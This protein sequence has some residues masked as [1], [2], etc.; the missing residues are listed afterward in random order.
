[1]EKRQIKIMKWTILVFVLTLVLA[2][3][4]S[5]NSKQQLNNDS[6]DS[7]P[8]NKEVQQHM[9]IALSAEVNTLDPHMTNNGPD[10]T[11]IRQVFETLLRRDPQTMEYQPGLAESWEVLDDNTVQFKLRKDVTF[12]NGEPLNAEAV[13]FSVERLLNPDTKSPHTSSLS[14]I[15][16]VDV[17]DE[18]TVNIVTKEPYPLLLTRNT[19]AFTGSIIIV[20]PQYIQEK[21]DAYFGENPVGTGPYKFKEWAKGE[22]VVLEVNQDYWDGGDPQIKEVTFHIIPEASTRISALLTGDVDFIERVPVDLIG[23]LEHGSDDVKV[24]L[25]ENGGY[26]MMMQLNPE[27]HPALKDKRV[28]QALNYAVDIDTILESIFGGYVTRVPVPADPKAFGFHTELKPYPYDPEKAKQLLAEAGYA[29]GFTLD[30]YTSNDRYPGDKFIAEAY[31]AQLEAVGV[32]VNLSTMEWGKLVTLMSQGQAGPMYQI[33]W[34]Y[35]EFDISKLVPAL[36]PSSG[37]STFDNEEF[38][39]LVDEAEKQMDPEKRKELWWQ[40]QE[41]LVEEAPFIHAWMPNLIY[42]ARSNVNISLLGEQYHVNQ[43][44]ID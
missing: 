39:R 11:V 31:T 28:R 32:K 26:A 35:S 3:C 33:G 30:A 24:V 14:A 21:G 20:P 4:G 12:H 16:R 44:T 6:A 17:I 34:T 1:M 38:A 13:K 41:V 10:F 22:K 2:G 9:A 19:L 42:G 23:R 5:S 36:H 18:H 7:S 40:A 27:A 29:D 8:A 25:S 37:Y 15:D 43:V